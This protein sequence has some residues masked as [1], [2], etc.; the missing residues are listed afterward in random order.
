[1]RLLINIIRLNKAIKVALSKGVSLG[2]S[3]YTNYA[4][5]A[6]MQSKKRTPQRETTGV[7]P[8]RYRYSH[9]DRLI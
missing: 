8:S 4:R 6:R 2:I 5:S 7:M 3:L 1:M 9:A